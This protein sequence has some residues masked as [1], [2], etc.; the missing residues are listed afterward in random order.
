MKPKKEGRERRRHTR[1]PLTADVAEPVEISFR[2]PKLSNSNRSVPAILANF[3][4]GGMALIAFGTQGLL[5]PNS[6]IQLTANFPGMTPARI[7]C[8][9][10]RIH[11]RS[12]MQTLGVRFTALSKTVRL[13]FQRIVNDYDDCETRIGLNIPEVC[14]GQ[15]CRYYGL[16]KKAQ[17][18]TYH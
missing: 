14:I 9:I 4:P 15:K 18:L 2:Q 17:K 10:V 6:I 16:C 8:K 11:T 12:E 5:K 13:K 1:I 7:T 3:S